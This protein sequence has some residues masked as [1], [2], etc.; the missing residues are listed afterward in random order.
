MLA[1][2]QGMINVQMFHNGMQ[3]DATL[4]NVWYVPDAS[5]HLFSIKA[6]PQNGYST[7]LNEK[8]VVIRRGDGTV[9]ASGKL[10]NS[11]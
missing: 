9:A 11:L 8:E 4:K 2:G 10:V 3:H 1:Y 5:A 6:A 7:T